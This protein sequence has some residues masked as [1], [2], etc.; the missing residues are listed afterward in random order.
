ML[1]AAQHETA[2]SKQEC[3]ELEDKIFEM[4]KEKAVLQ[5]NYEQ[6]ADQLETLQRKGIL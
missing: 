1:D 5:D 6:Q 3:T 2:I 4:E